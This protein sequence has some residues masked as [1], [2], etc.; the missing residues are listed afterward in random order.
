M[1]TAP[2]L[3]R[4]NYEDCPF[5]E[6]YRHDFEKGKDL[7][8]YL[9]LGY[10]GFTCLIAVLLLLT[11]KL[12]NSVEMM[13]EKVQ[14][15]FQDRVVLLLV[16]VDFLQYIG[17]G[18]VLDNNQD[19]I[20]NLLDY[21]SAGTLNAIDF[22]R[23]GVYKVVLNSILTLV[24]VWFIF[25]V[26]VWM[27]F[28]GTPI[29]Y[30]DKLTTLGEA[31]MPLLGNAL[32]LPITSVLFDVFI[33]EEA[34]GPVKSDLDYSDSFMFRD[35]NEDCWGGLHRKYVIAVT[36]ALVLY[37]PITVITRPLWQELVPDM[38]LKTRQTFYL[39][40]SLVEVMLV[41]IRRGLRSRSRLAHGVVY[42]AVIF[43]HLVL[44]LIHKPF[45]YKRLNLW[46][47]FSM[48]MVLIIGTTSLLENSISGFTDPHAI[49]F[50]FG[51][52]GFLLMLGIL[53]QLKLF[54]SLLF[55]QKY[56]YLP[57]LFRFGFDLRNIKPP[58]CIAK[59][60]LNYLFSEEEKEPEHL[61]MS[62]DLGSS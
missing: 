31:A 20:Q 18:P 58:E 59:R 55:D 61:V 24:L 52:G 29:R 47:S 62:S 17:H 26:L 34:H 37:H 23:E 35:C 51:V 14:V 25:S 28:R 22:K 7:V 54:P 8:L 53:V 60:K 16:L 5:P 41:G 42:I 43:I 6:E 57:E 39:Q 10:F 48:L 56:P 36:I 15:T 1:T 40:K 11:R 32:F 44:S 38:N 27:K 49:G 3:N 12:K 4:L 45:N 30:C 50:M 9:C 33:C 19:A 21:A 2:Q 13:T 46:F